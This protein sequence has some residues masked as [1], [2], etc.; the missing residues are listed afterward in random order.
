MIPT[1]YNIPK[2]NIFTPDQI[3]S[4]RVKKIIL[5]EKTY[6]ELFEKFGQWSSIGLIFFEN[7]KNPTPNFEKEN[8]AW[9]LFPNIKNYPLEN[10]IVY[11]IQLPS[12]NL[13]KNPSLSTY[14]YFTPINI[15][16]NNH[17]N[18]LPDNIWGSTLPE[19]QQ[20]DYQQIEVGNVRRVTDD[21]TEIRL[22]NTFKEKL[23]IRPLLPFEGDVI[24]EGRWGN[25]IRFGSTVKNTNNSWST[26]GENGD[27]IT[28]IRNGQP[29]DIKDDSWIP[30]P[31]D[32]NKEKSSIWLT[33]TQKIPIK[34]SSKSYKSYKD[35]PIAPEKYTKSQLIINSGRILFNANE[36]HLMFCGK[37]SVNLN[38]QK[39]NID[40]KDFT[41]SSNKM[42]LG[43]K[44]ATEPLLLGNKTTL[45]LN[46]LLINLKNLCDVLPTVGTPLPGAPN[47]LVATEAAKLSTVITQ[48]MTDL[49]QIKSK[50]NFTI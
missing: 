22:G 28:I 49:E 12:T 19:S 25:S 48:L 5:D 15:W 1:R 27:P 32:I 26:V 11:I 47:I 21:S 35:Q 41:I 9:P 7:T 44:E 39:I 4:A 43:D 23:T 45:L 3:F 2:Q 40:T 14:Y 42:Y 38:S 31:E 29:D 20:K 24:Y 8:Y 17:H 34:V 33:S 50:Q 13:E 16:N 37:L 30:L 18:A 46:K 6:P 10:E 36:D